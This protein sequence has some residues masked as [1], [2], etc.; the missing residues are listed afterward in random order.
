MDF[1]RYD[2]RN[3]P[4]VSVRDGYAEWV[5]T[6]DATVQ[7]EMDLRLLERVRTVAW[8][9]I[10]RALDL[11]CGTGRIGAWLKRAGVRSIDGLD[12]TPQMLARA[13]ERGVYARLFEGD[14]ARTGL[15]DAGYDLVTQVLADE[16]LADLA[17]MYREAA[18]VTKPGGRLVVVGYHPHFLL[19]G[20]PTHFDR[21]PGQAVTIE[22]HLHL[23]SDR[24]KAAHP[25]GWVLDEMDERIVDDE[26][27]A[28]KP[29]WGRFAGLPVSFSMV[30][31][32][33]QA[34]GAPPVSPP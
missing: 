4:V 24:V 6:Y 5:A 31:R 8:A 10:D 30:W 17:P 18:R 14:L 16:H 11:A 28:K 22:T 29:K 26:V 21:A 20:I 2:K 1:A 34:G 25:A 32:R 9:S 15:D 19:N 27:V 12:L 7:D 23:L 3:Y 33:A 13:K